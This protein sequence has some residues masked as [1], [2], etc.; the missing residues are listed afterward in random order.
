MTLEIEGLTSQK[1]GGIKPFTIH[2]KN[3]KVN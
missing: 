2:K 3:K 1:G